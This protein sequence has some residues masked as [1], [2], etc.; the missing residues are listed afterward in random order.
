M[1]SSGVSDTLLRGGNIFVPF[2]SSP[3]FDHSLL[4]YFVLNLILLLL[5]LLIEKMT[6]PHDPEIN[7]NGKRKKKTEAVRQIMKTE[8]NI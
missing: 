8:I 6:L 5:F 2:P 1:L 3:W 4:F 7:G